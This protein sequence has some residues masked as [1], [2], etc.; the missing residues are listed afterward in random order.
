ML[1]LPDFSGPYSPGSDSSDSEC[2]GSG[3]ITKSKRANSSA[4]NDT[5]SDMMGNVIGY[6]NINGGTK[7]GTAV[8]KA[9]DSMVLSYIILNSGVSSRRSRGEP[10]GSMTHRH[11]YL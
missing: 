1:S 3:L 9:T 6:W 4:S 11:A 5:L 7:F 10:G 8:L 2:L